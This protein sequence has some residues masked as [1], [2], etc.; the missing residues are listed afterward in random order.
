MERKKERKKREKE[1]ENSRR[2]V[3]SPV[4]EEISLSKKTPKMLGG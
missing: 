3:L 4:G 1:K 2:I